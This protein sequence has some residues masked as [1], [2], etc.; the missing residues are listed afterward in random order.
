VPAETTEGDGPAE[1][2]RACGNHGGPTGL[3]RRVSGTDELRS[4]RKRPPRATDCDGTRRRS[5]ADWPD[6]EVV[7]P[8]PKV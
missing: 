6:R 5:R 3:R 8:G 1:G 7:P 4:Y 2:R